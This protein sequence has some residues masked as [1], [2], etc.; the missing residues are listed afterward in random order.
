ME[1]L[2]GVLGI[3]FGAI[4]IGMLGV[5]LG[6]ISIGMT[7]YFGTKSKRLKKKIEIH[8]KKIKKIE[9]YTNSTGYKIVIHD[10]FHRISYA[11]GVFLVTF[12]VKSFMDLLLE[13]EAVISISN[14][15]Y[16]GAYIGA[17]L[18]LLEM[19]IDLNRAYKP[20]ESISKLETKIDK[21]KS[22]IS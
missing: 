5:A 7:W 13:N 18:V 8:E 17:G 3:L 2:L 22:E 6:V 16:S 11:I 20:K 1:L 15:F 10:S 9:S 21:A 4:S 19:F 12:G 14:G